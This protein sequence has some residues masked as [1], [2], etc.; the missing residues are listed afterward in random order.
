MASDDVRADEARKEKK[1]IAI[2]RVCE[3]GLIG[4]VKHAGGELI[5]LSV[6]LNQYDCLLT[7]RAVLP[8]GRMV[9]F[10]GADTLATA[11]LKAAREAR[12]DDLNWREDRFKV[13]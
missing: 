9:A 1:L 10:I 5:G 8:A 13:E 4:A 3:G 7:L 6:K 12:S 2:G 11:L